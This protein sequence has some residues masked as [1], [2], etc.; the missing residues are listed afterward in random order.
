MNPL[1]HAWDMIDRKLRA[2][3][4]KPSNLNELW[5]ALKEEW[6]NLDAGYIRTLYESMPCRVETLLEAKGGHTRY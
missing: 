2:R 6:E 5:T 1:E 3:H 4:P